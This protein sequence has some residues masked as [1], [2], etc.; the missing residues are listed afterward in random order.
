MTT[1]R[2]PTDAE[3]L[4]RATNAKRLGARFRTIKSL[5]IAKQLKIQEPVLADLVAEIVRRADQYVWDSPTKKPRPAGWGMPKCLKWLI[6]YPSKDVE[7]TS[8]GEDED[9]AYTAPELSEE[10][11]T[12]DSDAS[13]DKTRKKRKRKALSNPTSTPK[14]PRLTQPA[15]ARFVHCLYETLQ[16]FIES[17]G[18]VNRAAKCPG[19]EMPRDV[20]AEKCAA[21]FNDKSMTFE[22]P[23]ADAL[24]LNWEPEAQPY[25]DGVT[26]GPGDMKSFLCTVKADF[27]EC[28]VAF[29]QSGNGMLASSVEAAKAES[30]GAAGTSAT[31]GEEAPMNGAS[32]YS[33]CA[34]KGKPGAYYVYCMFSGET[35]FF[36]TLSL[37]M[38][39]GTG[40]SSARG[41]SDPRMHGK[42]HTG[43]GKGK[44]M[45]EALVGALQK[46]VQIAL[47]ATEQE[48][49]AARLHKM[50]SEAAA[51]EVAAWEVALDQVTKI[52][53]KMGTMDQSDP[54]Y[55]KLAA[56]KKRLESSL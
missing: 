20:W 50:K 30:S 1:A 34:G 26:V 4:V 8:D 52:S 10:T 42:R 49:A 19:G 14:K 7:V 12:S 9:G 40:A 16:E 29:E 15:F 17:E 23:C 53:E 41:A 6:A 45:H 44:G 21:V 39:E 51:A 28:K 25:G 46:P 38:P 48:E 3:Q 13:D 43:K 24:L 33:I 56:R 2:R 18:V 11:P 36:N 27:H 5:G 35:D 37:A 32:F 31:A 54:L 55:A 22:K 47:S